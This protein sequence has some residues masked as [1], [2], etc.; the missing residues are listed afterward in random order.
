[1][2][3]H[4]AMV[5]VSSTDEG[6]DGDAVQE[7][8]PSRETRRR[9]AAVSLMTLS[10]LPMMTDG[11]KV[12]TF[13]ARSKG[14]SCSRCIAVATGLEERAVVAGLGVLGTQVRVMV[15]HSSCIECRTVGAIFAVR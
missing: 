1:M 6:S 8:R 15:D 14:P 11:E 10:G 13:V 3:C 9:R 12:A 2:N 7:S 5:H 4:A